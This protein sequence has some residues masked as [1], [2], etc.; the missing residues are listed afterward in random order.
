MKEI[1]KIFIII[2]NFTLP[3]LLLMVVILVDFFINGSGA[4]SQIAY[5]KHKNLWIGS[6]I[7]LGSIHLFL[8]SRYLKFLCLRWRLSV[9]CG[10]ALLYVYYLLEF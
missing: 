6:Y 10:L 7:V 1:Q 3:Y 9:C 8:F 4:S 2:L 5:Q